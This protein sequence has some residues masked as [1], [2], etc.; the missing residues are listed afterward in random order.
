M[1]QVSR[2]ID[3]S[4]ADPRPAVLTSRYYNA[5]HHGWSKDLTSKII[6]FLIGQGEEIL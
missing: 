4:L 1:L 3:S 2:P 5:I 6:Y